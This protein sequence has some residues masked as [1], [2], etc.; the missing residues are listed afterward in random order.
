MSDVKIRIR[1][2]KRKSFV[3]AGKIWPVTV[4]IILSLMLFPIQ[5]KEI[6]HDEEKIDSYPRSVFKRLFP[7]SCR[8]YENMSK[9]TKFQD[10]CLL[11]LFHSCSELIEIMLCPLFLFLFRDLSFGIRKLHQIHFVF[12][13]I[14]LGY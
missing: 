13:L 10:Y 8:C 12:L 5:E 4:W 9:G 3:T 11:F 14:V 2:W 6:T 1:D 7:I